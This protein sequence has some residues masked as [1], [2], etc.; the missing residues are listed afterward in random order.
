MPSLKTY[1]CF[2]VFTPLGLLLLLAACRQK[3][4]EQVEWS[5]YRGDKASS[6]YSSLRQINKSNL[7]KLKVAWTFHTGD[8]R[9]GNRS[10]IQCNPLVVNG[11]MYVTSPQLTLIA[12]HPTSGKEA[13]RFDPFTG[14]EAT[15]VN[16]GVTYRADG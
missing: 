3:A 12:L 9:E 15:G 4:A 14:E 1:T 16:R 11:L 13:W 10:T 5:V 8:A 7:S 6:G 2:K